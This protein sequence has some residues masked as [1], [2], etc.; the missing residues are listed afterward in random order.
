MNQYL[1]NMN[2][3]YNKTE[4]LMD[5]NLLIIDTNLIN[6][7]SSFW[8][9]FLVNYKKYKTNII[10]IIDKI[11]YYNIDKLRKYVNVVHV[12]QQ[13][14]KN[15]DFLNIFYNTF[16]NKYLYIQNNKEQFM[17]KY[18]SKSTNCL[19]DVLIY[20]N[21]ENVYFVYRINNKINKYIFNT[22]KIYNEENVYKNKCNLSDILKN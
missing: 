9:Y 1:E 12:I 15:D 14:Y 4:G 8:I 11:M 22:Y 18:Y 17:N 7:N 13:L 19:L 21:D 10:I 16:I 2:N 20:N 5:D 3:L 6:L